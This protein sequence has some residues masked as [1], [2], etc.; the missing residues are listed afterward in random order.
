MVKIL[1]EGKLELSL[2]Q[3]AGGDGQLLEFFRDR[4]DYY[5]REVRGYPYDEVRA[6]MAA[7]CDN[8]ADLERRLKALHEVRPT[9][10]FEPVAASFKRIK[11]ILRQAGFPEGSVDETLIEQ[12]PERD[13]Y[14]AVGRVSG[15]DL[16]EIAALRPVVDRYFDK[17]LVNAADARIRAN[18]L[19]FLAQLLK[20]FSSVADFSEIV[21]NGLG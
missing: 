2:A 19:A 6:A 8:L 5:F 10:N 4:V 21:T 20:K 9:E 13:L 14:D 12:G 3:L 7:G 1:V 18:R 16:A 11:N 15:E 17:V